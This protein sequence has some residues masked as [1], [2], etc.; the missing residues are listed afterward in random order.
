IDMASG[1]T[2]ALTTHRLPSA[3]MGRRAAARML[4]RLAGRDVERTEELP[5]ELIVRAST[6]PAPR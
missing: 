5:A 1:V 6:G 3:D 2:P 4:A